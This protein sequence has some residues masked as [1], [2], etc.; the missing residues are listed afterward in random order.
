MK[1]L[2]YMGTPEFAVAPLKSLHEAGIDISAVVTVQDKPKGRG[3]TIQMS[4]VKVYALEHNIPVLQPENLKSETF[5]NEIRKINPDLIAIVAFR[6]LPEVLWK[7]PELGTINLHASLLPQYRG[8]APINHAIINGEVETGLTTFFINENIDAGEIL[9]SEKMKI[10]CDETAGELHDRMMVVGSELLLR[11][12]KGVYNGELKAIKQPDNP[13][14]KLKPAPKLF[15]ADGLIRF[16]SNT[17]SVFN[18]IRGLSP[19]PAAW[20]TL[21]SP[22]GQKWQM[23]VFKATKGSERYLPPCSINTDGKN[24][25]EIGTID[26]TISL[27]EV[28][29]ES[30]KRMKVDDLL[31]GFEIHNSWKITNLL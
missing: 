20:F 21:E 2:V 19:Y 15:K 27:K 23:K 10:Y 6:K 7:L 26:G 8:A 5:L 13:G 9:L 1:R 12:V 4:P 14:L 31:R 28:Q 29:L 18:L 24:Y 3:Q 30:K 25:I 11:T 16:N 22:E 17:D